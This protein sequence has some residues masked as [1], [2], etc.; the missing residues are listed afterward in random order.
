MTEPD[1]KYIRDDMAEASILLEAGSKVIANQQ[2]EIEALKAKVYAVEQ[3][4]HAMA[5]LLDLQRAEAAKVDHALTCS[6]QLI[7]ALLAWLPEGLVLSPDVSSTKGAWS[8]AMRK[9]TR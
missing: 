6:V 4:A 5:C 2:D 9:I 3:E 1:D 8:E 7:E